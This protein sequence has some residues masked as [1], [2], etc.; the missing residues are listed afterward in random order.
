MYSQQP[1]VWECG[2][3]VAGSIP[4]QASC[5]I[6]SLGRVRLQFQHTQWL[7]D[8]LK[9]VGGWR[10]DR[11]AWTARHQHS[12]AALGYA[13]NEEGFACRF[14][15]SRDLVVPVSPIAPWFER[16]KPH[17]QKGCHE[18]LSNRR[19]MLEWEMRTGKLRV[20]ATAAASLLV[21]Q[22]VDRVFVLTMST[23]AHEWQRQL[24]DQVGLDLIRLRGDV[25]MTA[26]QRQQIVALPYQFIL[27]PFENLGERGDDLLALAAAG[28][29]AV[30]ADEP[31]QIRDP[32]K[33]RTKNFIAMGDQNP[34]CAYAWAT[35]GTAMRNRPA[36]MWP[37]MEFL[38]SAGSY[39]T[40]AIRYCG[41]Y[42]GDYGYSLGTPRLNGELAARM[43]ALSS[44]VRRRDVWADIPKGDYRVIKCELS[45]KDRKAYEKMEKLLGSKVIKE[46]RSGAGS[47]VGIAA[48]RQLC[49]VTANAKVKTVIARLAEHT[50]Q[51]KLKAIV[52]AHTHEA[53]Q[54]LHAELVPETGA[55][56]LVTPVFVAGGWKQPDKRDAII[57]EWKDVQGPAILLANTLSSGI[58]IDLADAS[59]A[60]LLELSWV[61]NDMLQTISRLFDL[62]HGK[63]KAPPVFEAVLASGTVDEATTLAM[64]EKLRNIEAVFGASEEGSRFAESLRAGN[65]ADTNKLGLSSFSPEVAQAA[66]DDLT[67][68]LMSGEVTTSDD[69]ALV[70]AVEASFEGGEVETDDETAH[71]RAMERRS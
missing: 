68:R 2:V 70:G 55:P 59:V 34:N 61:P 51:S 69:A 13:I 60:I 67:A 35:T 14:V 19:W 65:I 39:W 45:G 29:Y 31:Q 6:D 44:Q 38:A 27:C 17:Q 20:A 40:F 23:L 54:K 8:L 32:K 42:S 53:L 1:I 50:E 36:D 26:A 33:L 12:L 15:I 62:Y 11:P 24:K 22:Q 46:L 16:L 48:L 41:A 4:L 57:Q 64:L 9:A 3:P 49:D 63:M 5:K 28:R 47:A 30:I 18:L 52:F 37:Q 7:I 58:G 21:A 10:W 25:L 56:A 66:I 43:Q 71:E